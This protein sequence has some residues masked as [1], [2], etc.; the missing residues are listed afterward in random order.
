MTKETNWKIIAIIFI[1][2][3]ILENALFIWAYTSQVKED[4]K[5]LECN[6]ICSEYTDAFYENGLCYCYDYDVDVLRD[7]VVTH[8]KSI[9]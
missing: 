1:I 6:D 7:I 3:F 9:N 8:T 4:N 2:L 5:K